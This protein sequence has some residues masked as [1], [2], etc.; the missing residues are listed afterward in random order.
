MRSLSCR[1]AEQTTQ[2]RRWPPAGRI[3]YSFNSRTWARAIARNTGIARATGDW[4]CFLDDDDL[5]HADKLQATVNYLESHPE[6]QAI[7]NPVWFFGDRE[8]APRVHSVFGAISWL[9][10]WMNAT[11]HVAGD[12]P[13]E[14]NPDYLWIHGK[15]FRLLLQRNR[16]VMSAS[17][18]RR[19]TLIRAGG[20]CPM[21]SY[22]EDW[23]M[24]VNVARL[25]QWHTL[26]RRLGFT[27]LHIG[28]SSADMS[29]VISVL[30]GQVNAWYGG[31]PM[32]HRTRGLD[33]VRELKTYGTVYRA[34][35]QG[36]LWNLIWNGHFRLAAIVY[37]LGWLL[38]PR[39]RDRA[40]ALTP[41]QVT[42]RWERYVLGRH[43][44]SAGT[45]FPPPSG[46]NRLTTPDSCRLASER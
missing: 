7:N 2:D 10:T 12:D 36:Y 32:P 6:A 17:V 4:V 40:Y 18:V 5:W 39:L 20:F 44:G 30:C 41:P 22:T 45:G 31:R 35:V 46:S 14:N 29:N 21:Q 11:P 26:P 33:M 38:L 23:T 13:S 1:T 3:S 37:R 8:D 16:G 19:E 43:R 34:G 28:Q 24:F 25:T 9:A 27:R 15:S 42:W